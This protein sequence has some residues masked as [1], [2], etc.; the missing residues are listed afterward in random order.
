M[1]FEAAAEAQGVVIG[2]RKRTEGRD[3]G[4][5]AH[6][7]GLPG[8]ELPPVPASAVEMNDAARRPGADAGAGVNLATEG[9]T[10]NMGEFY[11]IKA[12]QHKEKSAF[13]GPRRGFP[14]KAVAA[15][16]PDI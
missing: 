5:R 4:Y 14:E 16:L 6:R 2:V 11:S 8:N 12:L 9:C 7:M 1:D 3:S 15:Q 13:R 10:L